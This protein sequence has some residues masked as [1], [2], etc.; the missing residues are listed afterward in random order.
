MVDCL[1]LKELRKDPR[2]NVE[3]VFSSVS[4]L[5]EGLR[6]GEKGKLDSLSRARTVKDILVFA[7]RHSGFKIARD[8]GRLTIRTVSRSR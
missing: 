8:K 1:R 5:L 4:S 2:R 6:E 3:N 7:K